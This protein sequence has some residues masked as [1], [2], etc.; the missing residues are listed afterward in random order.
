MKIIRVHNWRV[1]SWHGEVQLHI[2]DMEFNSI[3]GEA[4]DALIVTD[5]WVVKHPILWWY[6]KRWPGLVWWWV[7][8]RNSNG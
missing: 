4:T 3:D 7:K 6:C 8:W 2:L 5:A 1:R